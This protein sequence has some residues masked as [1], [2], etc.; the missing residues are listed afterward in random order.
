MYVNILSVSHHARNG[1]AANQMTL[2][3]RERTRNTHPCDTQRG[4]AL[5]VDA[6]EKPSQATRAQHRSGLRTRST[7]SMTV[8]TTTSQSSTQDIVRLQ[9]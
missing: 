2:P 3:S 8:R 6:S 4:A 5:P 1:P 9:A 7:L